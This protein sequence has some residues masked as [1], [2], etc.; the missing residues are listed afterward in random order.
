MVS[1]KNA[2]ARPFLTAPL[3]DVLH[4]RGGGGGGA[5]AR[6]DA[7]IIKNASDSGRNQ[8][9]FDD[10]FN[11]DEMCSSCSPGLRAPLP[12]ARNRD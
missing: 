10:L 9:G 12:S 8:T 1:R 5:T 4:L 7:G 2:R 3:R 11:F 6:P